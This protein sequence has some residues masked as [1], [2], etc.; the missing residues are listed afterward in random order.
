MFLQMMQQFV[1]GLWLGQTSE[2]AAPGHVVHRR[3]PIQSVGQSRFY[4]LYL[5][6]MTMISLM[7]IAVVVMRL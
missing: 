3:R 1:V 2:R 6:G 4:G 5:A 7:A